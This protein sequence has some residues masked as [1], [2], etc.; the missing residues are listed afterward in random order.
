MFIPNDPL[1]LPKPKFVQCP[2]P[3]CGAKWYWRKYYLGKY[4]TACTACK[5]TV[6]PIEL[7]ESEA[8]VKI[9]LVK[10]TSCGGLQWFG[11]SSDMTR[12]AHCKNRNVRI[13]EIGQGDL[14]DIIEKAWDAFKPEEQE[15]YLARLRELK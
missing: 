8:R 7:D 14:K 1:L 5:S 4:K 11:G 15:Y 12:C 9:K 3:E 2:K 13:V 6:A 10:C